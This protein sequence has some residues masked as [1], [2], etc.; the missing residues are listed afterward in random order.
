M[1]ALVRQSILTVEAAVFTLIGEKLMVA[2]TRHAGG[3]SAGE[4][5]LPGGPVETGV[6]QEKADS[7]TDE[8]MLRILRGQIGARPRHMEQ[9]RTLAGPDHNCSG[10]SACVLHL[11]LIHH[12]A[13]QAQVE[14]GIVEL[15][16]AL[17]K[18]RAKGLAIDQRQRIGMAVEHLQARAGYSTIVAHLL[19]KVFSLPDLHEAYEA[20][21]GAERNR[22]SFR[23]KILQEG[24]LVEADMIR[25]TGG[26]P[27][28]GYRLREG[29]ATLGLP[30]I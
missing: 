3:P 13:I 11:V 5:A 7:S 17:P 22:D 10:W 4:L 8:A 24:V 28:Q 1:S 6:Q 16:E 20:V 9:I 18:T 26:K 23:R 29:L 15:H 2:L 19:P 25:F 27:A 21:T 12:E 30:T 14:A